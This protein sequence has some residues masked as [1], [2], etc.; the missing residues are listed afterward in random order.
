MAEKTGRGKFQM[1]LLCQVKG[2]SVPSDAKKKQT[3]TKPK[4]PDSNQL[5]TRFSISRDSKFRG[6]AG[7]RVG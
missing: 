3:N 7:S 2:I 4:N 5:K 6:K 1:A